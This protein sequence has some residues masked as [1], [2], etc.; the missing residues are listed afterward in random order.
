MDLLRAPQTDAS[1]AALITHGLPPA[2]RKAHVIVAGAGMAGLVAAYELHKAGHHVTLLEARARVGGRIFTARDR[3]A[4][5]ITAELGAMRI[6]TAHR[7]TMAYVERFGLP[8]APFRSNNDAAYSF[9]QG[10]RRRM[11]A[12]VDDAFDLAP[13][14]R[15]LGLGGLLDHTLAP[16]RARIEAEGE[17]GWAAVTDAWELASLREFLVRSG[18]SPG[19]IDLFGI[20]ARHETLMDTSFLE[21]FRGSNDVSSP[22][23]RILGGMDQLPRAFLLAIGEHVRYGAE[24]RA[25]EQGPQH[26]RVHY[27]NAGGPR[28]VTGDYL[29]IT[30]PY[31]VLGHVEV[32]PAFS[33]TKR[34]ALRQIHYDN[35][36]KIFLQFRRR[37]WE[38]DGIGWGST[39]TDLPIRNVVYPEPE[40]GT[41]RG[42]LLASYTWAQ[43]AHRWAALS[44]ADRVAQALENVGRIHP[45]AAS[46]FE[47]GTSHVWQA[48][49]YAC[50]AYTVFQPGQ[51]RRLHAAIL[52]P[53]GRVHFAGEHTSLLHRWIEGAV[54][55]G[56]RAALEVSLAAQRRSGLGPLHAVRP[57]L[58]PG[59]AAFE[60]A[61]AA[62]R[63]GD[64]DRLRAEI[65]AHP[66]VLGQ[67]LAPDRAGETLLHA[68]IEADELALGAVLL[69]A[70]ADASA[71]DTAG[72][73]PLVLAAARPQ[74]E[75]WFD[76]LR[77]H[78]ADLD[79]DDGA[80]LHAALRLG[81]RG[82]APAEALITR[83][84]RLDL[85]AAAALGDVEAVRAWLA[86][87]ADTP[88]PQ[89][90]R[91]DPDHLDEADR[92][93]RAHEA[94]LF[95]AR[96][97]QI[98]ALEAL[99][100]AADDLD[101]LVSVDGVRQT[102]LHA[103]ARHDEVEAVAVLLDRGAD[104]HVADAEWS[105]SPLG[106]AVNAGSERVAA[107]LRARCPVV[108]D[109][110]V[111]V[112]DL[113]AL[114]AA[115][116]DRHPDRAQAL[117]TPGVLLRN[118]ALVGRAD[119]C[120]WLIAAGADPGLRSPVG[121]TAAEVAEAAGHGVLAGWL[122][123]QG[124][125]GGR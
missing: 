122:R 73:T 56:L 102:A 3:F 64:P 30:L 105:S 40:H 104:P 77:R 16:L 90:Y 31:S 82:L 26:V 112:G 79:E 17:A 34:R 74:A 91:P 18:W 125:A 54:E 120:A 119:V 55:S 7:L 42:L 24:V 78:G 41:D 21:F 62:V 25:I 107:L 86:A 113:D 22:M 118:A 52:Q 10:V 49:P 84:A 76:L 94:L 124:G 48:D 53:E 103:A 43:D 65:A 117:G 59:G 32:T 69:D 70:G 80:P 6:P 5:G 15:G 63:A 27:T 93:G 60:R 44:E 36:S 81:R 114:R 33:D 37:F 115:L 1:L 12:S 108:I 2:R 96:A 99:C 14:E 4:D 35:A 85:A 111:Y 75:A 47:V 11:S 23:V 121:A 87:P 13:H 100:D 116:G 29:I 28:S 50:G 88:L 46:Y 8:T 71:A 68:A 45:E 97:G 38:D 109:D 39:V 61:L 67:H 92:A 57:P 66:E 110:L 89:R 58:P 106:W 20:M 83:G 51:Q 123:E 101:A 9:L 98:A 72:R 19:A 95:A